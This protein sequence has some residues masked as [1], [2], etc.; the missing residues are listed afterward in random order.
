M[1][2]FKFHHLHQTLF[3]QPSWESETWSEITETFEGNFGS[4][5]FQLPEG[6]ITFTLYANKIRV[7]YKQMGSNLDLD[8]FWEPVEITY[9]RKDLP[10]Q[11]EVIFTLS[12]KDQVE[13]VGNSWI[14]KGEPTM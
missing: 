8:D 3:Y 9:Y 4:L 11:E 2:K 13:K 12:E 7:F 5:G 10:K 6:W 14:K 1:L